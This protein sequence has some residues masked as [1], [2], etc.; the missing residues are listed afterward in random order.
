MED[1]TYEKFDAYLKERY[2]EQINYYE[3]K[4]GWNKKLYTLFQWAV[5]IISA[6]M[7]VLVVSTTETGYLNWVSA[8]L[9]LLLA[10]GTSVLKAFKYQENWVSYRQ[11]AEALKRERHLYDADLGSYANNADK[12]AEFVNHV[13]YLI[14][15][16]N[17]S[18]T[19]LQQQKEQTTSSQKS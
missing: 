18:W 6:V 13:E 12:R 4:A 2:L 11:L 3:A 10:I 15:L 7:P 1:M 9:S 17:A 16:E 19:N 8:A 14:A 5:I